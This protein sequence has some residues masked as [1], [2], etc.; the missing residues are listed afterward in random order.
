M[1][2]I[3]LAENFSLSFI[4]DINSASDFWGYQAQIVKQIK[5]LNPTYASYLEKI[6]SV[7][8]FYTEKSKIVE[9]LKL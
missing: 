3:P 4:K 7:Y 5:E 2:K 1:P 9:E 8:G 6:G